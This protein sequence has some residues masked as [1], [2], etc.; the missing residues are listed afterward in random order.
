MTQMLLFDPNTAAPAAPVL[1]VPPV[2]G[3]ATSPAV[4]AA[5]SV[6]VAPDVAKPTDHGDGIHQMGDLA[7]LVLLR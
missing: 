2:S 5:S 4:S 3:R 1:T 6:S 7:R